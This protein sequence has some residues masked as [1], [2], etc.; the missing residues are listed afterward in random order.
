[1][2]K[3]CSLLPC[4]LQTA[5]SPKT[6]REKK[7]LSREKDVLENRVTISMMACKSS[8]YSQRAECFEGGSVNH[9]TAI[10]CAPSWSPA[11]KRVL[12]GKGKL[13]P[14]SPTKELSSFSYVLSRMPQSLSRSVTE[15]N[16]PSPNSISSKPAIP[17]TFRLL[18]PT[19]HKLTRSG[20]PLGIFTEQPLPFS[21]PE[22]S[23]L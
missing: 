5:E 12:S 19:L 18:A 3:G 1:M 23:T 9:T 11:G 2:V 16:V 6:V 20:I 17:N 8:H 10:Q 21:F 7:S 4:S 13:V 22:L 14:A 15:K